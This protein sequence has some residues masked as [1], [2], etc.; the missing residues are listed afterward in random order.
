MAFTYNPYCTL[1]DAKM[2]LDP[3]MGTSD[4]QFIEQLIVQAQADIDR[5][6]GYPFQ[7]DG[8]G[9]V[10]LYD[11]KGDYVLYINDTLSLTQVLEIQQDSVL[12]PDGFWQLGAT[13]TTDITADC[14]LKPNN[15]TP[16][17]MLKRRSGLPFEEGIVNYQVTGTFGYPTTPNQLYPGIPADITRITVRLVTH[18][19]KMRDTNYA[20]MLQD[21]SVR[22]RYIK[23]MPAD[24]VEVIRR[25]KRSLFMSAAD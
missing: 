10:R 16:Q 21:G 19:Y 25:Y 15:D 5:E 22:E 8:P 12:G 7:T 24:V 3:N 17:Y 11:G 4:D 1:A 23:N 13:T 9:A 14:V 6:I 2:A 18:Y 20:D